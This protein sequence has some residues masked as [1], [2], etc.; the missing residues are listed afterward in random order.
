MHEPINYA[1]ASYAVGQFPP[2]RSL[3]FEDPD[4]FVNVVRN[5]IAAHVAV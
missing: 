1:V 2:G 5:L 3:T 4:A